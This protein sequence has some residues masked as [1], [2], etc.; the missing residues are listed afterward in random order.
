MSKFWYAWSWYLLN[1]VIAT[2]L[3]AVDQLSIAVTIWINVIGFVFT[4]LFIYK[5]EL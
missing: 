3:F 2:T 1:A 5:D 4:L